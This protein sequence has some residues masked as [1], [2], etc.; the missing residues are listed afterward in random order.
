MK[1]L[2]YNLIFIIIDVVLSIAFNLKSLDHW[3]YKF[4]L[5]ICTVIISTSIFFISI[6]INER[7]AGVKLIYNLIITYIFSYLILEII[8]ALMTAEK[9]SFLN[10]LLLQYKDME[11][12]RGVSVP[13]ILSTVITISVCLIARSYNRS[14]FSASG[15]EGRD[16][17]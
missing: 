11:M 9:I 14:L 5:L 6:V 10:K 1:I 15:K 4:F 7:F 13:Y 16:I 3:M 12:F 2:K 17:T 8:L